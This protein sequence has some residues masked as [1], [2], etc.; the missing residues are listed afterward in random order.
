MLT[1]AIVG[2]EPVVMVVCWRQEMLEV[3]V[4]VMLIP[5]G[6]RVFAAESGAEAVCLYQQHQHEIDL[7]LLNLSGRHACLNPPGQPGDNGLTIFD[8]LRKINPAV[9]C[10]FMSGGADENCIANILNRGAVGFFEKPFRI[11]E[12]VK[13]M[14]EL[15]RPGVPALELPIT[16]TCPAPRP[17]GPAMTYTKSDESFAALPR[18][19]WSV[20][21]VQVM[22]AAGLVWL[23]TGANGENVIEAR[24]STQAEAWDRACQQ[25]ESLGMLG[26]VEGP[27]PW[28]E[29][30][31]AGR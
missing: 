15:S 24:G 4:E 19:G 30:A 13:A 16:P 5:A 17:R 25:A 1:G 22:T 14:R 28:A 3:I 8:A 29:R 31:A 9:R 11:G 12:F 27:R 26:E 10:A 21:D 6:F 7:V 23:V 2:F 18:A 20:G